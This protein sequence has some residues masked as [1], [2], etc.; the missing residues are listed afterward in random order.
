[1]TVRD[2][3]S[4]RKALERMR[5]GREAMARRGVRLSQILRKGES[6]RDL[7]HRGHKY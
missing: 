4:T 6:L 7:A 5:K 3:E 1:M 2:P